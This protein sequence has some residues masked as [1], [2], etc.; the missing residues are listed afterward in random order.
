[1]NK[2]EAIKFIK[3]QKLAVIAT[4]SNAGQPESAV[5]AFAVTE[6]LELVFATDPNSRKAANIQANPRVALTIGWDER[7]TIQCEG[8]A[9]KLSDDQ[10]EDY[11]ETY[12]AKNPFARNSDSFIGLQYFVV[13]PDWARY[14]DINSH[15]WRVEQVELA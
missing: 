10:A 1:M 12:F 15:P 13:K 5:I 9:E 11:K 3:N 7:E 6:Q 2:S 8:E 4:V 14:T